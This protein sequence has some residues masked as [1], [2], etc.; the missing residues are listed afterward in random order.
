[1]F[2]RGIFCMCY[3]LQL[4]LTDPDRAVRCAEKASP[5]SAPL[6]IFFTECVSR[7]L[8]LLLLRTGMVKRRL[9]EIR[10]TYTQAFCVY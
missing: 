8:H 1:M 7:T 4:G 3:T 6:I 2:A 10:E 5:C 9:E